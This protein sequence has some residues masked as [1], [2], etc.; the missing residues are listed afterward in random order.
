MRIFRMFAQLLDVDMTS[1]PPNDGDRPT[2][3]AGAGKW[4]PG[5]P[6]G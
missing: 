2:W 4:V 6:S 3:D 1:T 5:T